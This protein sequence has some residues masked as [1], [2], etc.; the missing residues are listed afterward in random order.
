MKRW[1]FAIVFAGGLALAGGQAACRITYGPP[2]FYSCFA[3]QN[4]L[5][6]G[7]VVLAG[8][9]E[10]RSWPAGVSLTPYLLVT[11]YGN[12]WFALQFGRDLRS[13]WVF[14]ISGGVSW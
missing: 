9:V 13:G 7:P 1:V 14:T 5:E 6:I 8:G 12:P 10:S 2:L 11:H 4:L 3:E